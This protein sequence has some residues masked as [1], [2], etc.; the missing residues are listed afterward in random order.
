MKRLL[1][2]S[3]NNDKEML[4]APVE[5]MLAEDYLKNAISFDGRHRVFNLCRD[6]SYCK[7]GYYVSLIAEAQ[8]HRPIPNMSTLMDSNNPS[9]LKGIDEEI[10][11]DLDKLFK[12]IKGD[13]FELSVF[14]GQNM[15]T[16]YSSLARQLFSMYQAPLLKALFS[17]KQ[18]IWVLHRIKILALKDIPEKHLDFLAQSMNYYFEKAPIATKRRKVSKYDMAILVNPDELKP[19]SDSGALKKFI[20]AAEELRI[21]AEIIGPG[22]ASKI[23]QF[24]ALFIR[25]TTSV[26]NHTFR[27]AR[28]AEE[29]GLVV[30]DDPVSILRCCNKIYLNHALDKKGIPTPR[31]K[32]ISKFE[33]L[34]YQSFQYPLVIKKPDSAFSLGVK[35]ADDPGEMETICK[36]FFKDTDLLLIQEYTPTEFD[37][38]VGIINGEPLYLCRYHMAKGHWQIVD[39]SKNQFLEGAVD[40]LSVGDAPKELMKTALD[41]AATIGNG[42]YGIDLKEINGR[43]VV[44]EV[45]DN[46]SIEKG[47]E[48][49][50]IGNFLY[51]KIM[52]TFFQRME[53]R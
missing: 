23:S 46:P 27:L 11:Q 43:Y 49:R 21:N 34:D 10:P 45:N 13:S 15:A 39:S 44:I 38:R 2:V 29:E 33:D 52:G 25:E 18:D 6:L 7:R 9:L 5:T 42:L 14:F 19:P 28:K 1:V 20:N 22:D 16:K 26:N 3:S 41:A 51:Q 30:I 48:D 50:V 32:V 12:G 17:K 4:R 35:R 31:T 8:G 53:L 36:L 47:Y 24:D 37:W 40:T